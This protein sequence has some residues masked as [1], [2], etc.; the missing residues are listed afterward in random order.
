[1]SAFCASIDWPDLITNIRAENDKSLREERLATPLFRLLELARGAA[2]LYLFECIQNALDA[3][4]SRL[5]ISS[6]DATSL[7]LAHDN[8]RRSEQG[9]AAEELRSI[10]GVCVST[11][12]LSEVGF[13]GKRFFFRFTIRFLFS[14]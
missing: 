8:A 12:G 2:D 1:M 3:G 14:F 10:C 5:F 11:K 13:M 7:M 9:L 4:A 6:L